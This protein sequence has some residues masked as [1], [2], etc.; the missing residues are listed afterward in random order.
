MKSLCWIFDLLI[1]NQN[2][3]QFKL[4][5]QKETFNGIKCTCLVFAEL[6]ISFIE[7]LTVIW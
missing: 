2:K 7:V 1:F 3:G 4:F 6:F 5:N